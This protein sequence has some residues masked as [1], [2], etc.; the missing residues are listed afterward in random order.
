M[1]RR[2]FLK[3]AAAVFP[4]ARL[5]ALAFGQDSAGS[6]HDQI[7]AVGAGQ[8]H[9][10][11][12]HSLGF[13]TILFKTS[14]RE[15]NGS[16]FVIEHKN[17]IKGGP[18]VHVHLHQDEWWYVLEGEVL[19]QVGDKRQSLRPG[20][21]ILGPRGVPH[22]FTLVSEKPGRMVIAFTPAGKMEQFFRDVAVRGGPKLDADV[23]RRYD[24]EMV[25]PPLSV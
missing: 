13:S 24:M 6:A 25:G 3:T 7:Q 18:P 8:D 2:A 4:A 23:F 12:T 20:D 10:G 15:T 5:E 16:L 11:E 1:E 19:F 21:S 14:T 22:G 17:L 9:S